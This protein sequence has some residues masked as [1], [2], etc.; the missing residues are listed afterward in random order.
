MRNALRRKII[1]GGVFCLPILQPLVSHR[2]M[3]SRTIR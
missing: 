2:P 3:E 1:G